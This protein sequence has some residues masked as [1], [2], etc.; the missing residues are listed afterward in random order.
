MVPIFCPRFPPAMFNFGDVPS[1]TASSPLQITITN[2]TQ[3]DVHIFPLD[4]G[5]LFFIATAMDIRGLCLRYIHSIAWRLGGLFNGGRKEFQTVFISAFEQLKSQHA[6]MAALV[7][8]VAALRTAL[9]ENAPVTLVRYEQFPLTGL[10]KG[11]LS[12][13]RKQNFLWT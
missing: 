7:C 9:L 8:D 12:L 3:A 4:Y 10:W 1:N 11:C 6:T 2:P 13:N 5:F